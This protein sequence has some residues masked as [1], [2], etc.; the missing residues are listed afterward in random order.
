MEWLNSL[1]N[2]ENGSAFQLVMITLALVVILVLL[3]WLFKRIAGTPARR[4]SRNRV[5]RLSITDVTAVDD[6]RFLILARR[7]NVEHLLLIGGSNDLVVETDIVR[8][9]LGQQRAQQPGTPAARDVAETAVPVAAGVVGAAAAGAALTAT[10][11]ESAATE[12][13]AEETTQV[14]ETIVETASSPEAD[15][16]PATALDTAEVTEVASPADD[17]E[18]LQEALETEAT[19]AKNVED[20]LTDALDASL[21]ADLD[22][23]ISQQ[24][25][26][27]LTSGELDIATEIETASTDSKGN[28][29]EEDDMQKLLRELAAETR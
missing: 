26:V 21:P 15:I 10:T 29:A 7:D 8:T 20:E 3:V 25:D 9:Q 18:V 19:A 24:L 1:L 16:Q 4:A 12:S 27:A 11:E 22:A 23:E 5:P 2:G 17:L 6:K 13:P 14:R 28:G